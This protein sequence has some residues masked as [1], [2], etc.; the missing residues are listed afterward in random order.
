VL[1]M[2]YMLMVFA[3]EITI[4]IDDTVQADAAIGSQHA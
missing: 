4:S 3:S 1:F 2:V